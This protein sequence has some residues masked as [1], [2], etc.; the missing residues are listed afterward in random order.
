MI[1]EPAVNENANSLMCRPLIRA[2]LRG[3]LDQVT[4]AWRFWA[5]TPDSVTEGFPDSLASGLSFGRAAAWAM[6]SF[7]WSLE[8]SLMPGSPPGSRDYVQAEGPVG[9]NE[10]GR[11]F[12]SALE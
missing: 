3:D 10:V 5:Y 1:G 4:Q 6:S 2:A 8:N 7:S 11:L 12:T 9:T